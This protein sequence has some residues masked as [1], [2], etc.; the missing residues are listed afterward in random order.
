[1]NDE[2]KKTQPVVKQQPN[3]SRNDKGGKGVGGITVDSRTSSS[4]SPK[5]VSTKLLDDSIAKRR[6]AAYGGGGRDEKEQARA[7]AKNAAVSG[8][9]RQPA[10]KMAT[11]TTTTTGTMS[12]YLSSK[13]HVDNNNN[14]DTDSNNES[15]KTMGVKTDSTNVRSS[16]GGNERPVDNNPTAA[17]AMLK[18]PPPG[19]SM[20]AGDQKKKA[21]PGVPETGNG[22]TAG[23]ATVQ[24]RAAM[25]NKRSSL[26]ELEDQR[27]LKA[28]AKS[29][30]TAS[31]TKRSPMATLAASSSSSSSSAAAA[32]SKQQS[33]RMEEVRQAKSKARNGAHAAAAGLTTTPGAFASSSSASSSTHDD[34]G[35]AKEKAGA[36]PFSPSSLR[37]PGVASSIL[38]DERYQRKLD[39]ESPSLSPAKSDPV[40]KIGDDKHLETTTSLNKEVTPV[41]NAPEE[42]STFQ[43]PPYFT[44]FDEEQGNDLV[45]ATAVM[46]EDDDDEYIPKALEYDPDAKPPVIK[47]RRFRLY[48]AVVCIAMIVIAASTIGVLSLL[49]DGGSDPVPTPTSAP[50]CERCG[51]GIEEALELAVGSDK[52]YDISSPYNEAMEW[53]LYDDALQLGPTDSNLIQRFV[54]ATFYFDT[55]Q[56]GEW[57]ACNRPDVEKNEDDTCEH[58]LLSGIRPTLQYTGIPSNRWLSDTEECSWAGVSCDEFGQTRHIDLQAYEMQGTF[59]MVLSLLPYVQSF[60][61]PRNNFEGPLPD[62]I[63][64]MKH[65]TNVE[66]QFNSF[67]GSFPKAWARSRN[68]QLINVGGNLLSGSLPEEIGELTTVKGLFVMDNQ[69]TGPLPESFS[70]LNLLTYA[71]FQGNSFSG[72]IPSYFGDMALAELWLRKNPFSGELPSELGKLSNSLGDLRLD[73]TNVSGPLPE[74][75]WNLTNLW[76]LD[77]GQTKL[78]GTISSSVGQMEDLVVFDIRDSSF[79]GQLPTE[80]GALTSLESLTIQGNLLVGSVPDEVCSL[81]ESPDG[82]LQE[83]YTST[84]VACNATCCTHYCEPKAVEGETACYDP[85]QFPTP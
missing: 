26:Y 82:I 44:G 67:T 33:L 52:L 31:M 62:D 78:S 59:P 1:M 32:G 49:A 28:K 48:M 81:R 63:G 30:S 34:G 39:G 12:Q 75:I 69:F 55:H 58:Q 65:L 41:D 6:A 79:T 10:A 42:R 57:L 35:A 2:D 18:K 16:S 51:L 84:D 74:E 43:S 14:N 13:T 85:A 54:L 17:T 72:T 50:T 27:N 3:Q 8:V 11:T 15:S 70:K 20:S 23:T 80:M 19:S 76:R 45:V 61:F 25:S 56:S 9:R 29:S 53:I 60:V 47:N 22:N 40:K 37:R 66:F 68:L 21:P 73:K 7:A 5:S 71:R 46:E 24:S 64:N 77:L 4:S 83:I 38:Q 36:V